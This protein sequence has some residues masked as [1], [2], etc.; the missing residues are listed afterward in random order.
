ME[1]QVARKQE[2]E[3]L[4]NTLIDMYSTNGINLKK[5]KRELRKKF[6]IV[7][8]LNRLTAMKKKQDEKR[9]QEKEVVN[10]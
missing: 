6:N 10:E 8:S 3:S 7:V 1:Q 2:Q 5:V 9:E 4:I